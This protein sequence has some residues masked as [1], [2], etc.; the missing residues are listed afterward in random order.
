[1]SIVDEEP[2]QPQEQVEEDE[3][4][5]EIQWNLGF[6]E[7]PEKPLLLLRHRFPS[8][9]G[10][11]PAWLDPVRLPSR[12]MLTCKA[13]GKPLDFLLQVY[14]P[15]DANPEEGFHRALFLF[16]SPEGSRLKEPG[17]V[18]LFRCQIP[19]HNAFYSSDPPRD[20]DKYPNPLPASDADA[21]RERDP[22]RAVDAERPASATSSGGSASTSSPSAS[23]KRKGKGKA[24]AA[25]AAA[26][27]N[28]SAAEGGSA[29]AA[30]APLPREGV[31]GPGGLYPELELVVEPEEDYMDEWEEEDEE[32]EKSRAADGGKDAGKAGKKADG[33]AGDAKD[34]PEDGKAAE[35]GAGAGTGTGGADKGGARGGVEAEVRRALQEYRR[36]VATEGEL[37]DEELPP[38]VLEALEANAAPEQRCFVDFQA[39]VS[40]APEQVIRYCF[41]DGAQPLWPAPHCR[42]KPGDIPPCSRCGAARKPEFQVL[43]QLLHYLHLDEEDPASPDW[44]TLVAYTCSAS[45]SLPPAEAEASQCAYTEE[46]VWVQPPAT[47]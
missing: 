6:V 26:A 28:G 2:K 9:V 24:G 16:I 13:S 41:Q 38:D 8:K 37:N 45:C 25:A 14:A 30:A 46:V 21:S 27:A 43:P 44:S 18:R 5:D 29:A 42:P 10:G 22:W 39:R 4:P 1:M 36:R 23:A 33:E 34:E 19:R 40:W 20:K 32:E 31:Q 12:D 11:R 15:V 17:A 35:A 47:E 7:E 3:E